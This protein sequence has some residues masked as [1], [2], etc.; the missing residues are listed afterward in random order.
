MTHLFSPQR[1]EATKALR[2]KK[3]QELVNFMNESSER[4]EAVNISRASFITVLNIISNILFSVDIGSYDPKKPSE[5]QDTVIGVL[6][7]AGEPDL[8]NFFPFLGYLDLQGSRKKM[9]LCT[10]RLFRLFRG[11]IDAKV[12]EKSLQINPKNV[13]DRDFVDALLDLSEGDEAELNNE[14]IIEHL[15]LVSPTS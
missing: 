7:A 3:V 14:D 4:E 10:E 12:A 5:F 9:K 11:L 13:S 8:A 1:I 6:E 2:M 15:L